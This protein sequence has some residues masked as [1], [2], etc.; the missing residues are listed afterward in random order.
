MRNATKGKIIKTTALVVDVAAPLA[1]TLSQFPVWVDKSSTAT[2][3]GLFVVF[4][5]LSAI[6]LIRV[7]KKYL[8]SPAAWL[9]WTVITVFVIALRN[10]IDQMAIICL[11][12]LVSNLIGAGLHKIAEK[13]ESRPDKPTDG[14]AGNG[15][16]A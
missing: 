7:I 3:S 16:S 15:G 2:V 13:V 11:V 9:I 4:A 8:K 6:P 1:A 14:D 12:G 10:I 5:L